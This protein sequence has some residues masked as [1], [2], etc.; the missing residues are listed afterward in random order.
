MNT[1]ESNIGLPYCGFICKWYRGI[2]I[3]LRKTGDRVLGRGAGG[4]LPT[5]DKPLNE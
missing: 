2:D 5:S 4:Y 1:K 3:Q